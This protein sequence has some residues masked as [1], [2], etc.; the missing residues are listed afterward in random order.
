M[1]VIF[2][3]PSQ[4]ASIMF[5]QFQSQNLL[6]WMARGIEQRKPAHS[7][8]GR[9]FTDIKDSSINIVHMRRRQ[10][11]DEQQYLPMLQVLR[12]H[13]IHVSAYRHL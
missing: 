5:A 10:T 9:R 2:F 13:P 11:L 12:R 3:I 4:C 8:V 7:T 6:S 1:Q